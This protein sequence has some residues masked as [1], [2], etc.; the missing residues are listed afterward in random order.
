MSSSPVERF[1]S[2]SSEADEFSS[3]SEAADSDRV[4]QRLPDFV[5]FPVCFPVR[6][7]NR[8]P[9]SS[10]T[11]PELAQRT[12][13]SAKEVRALQ[14]R[15]FKIAPRGY[16][17]REQFR[18]TLG[19][20][21]MT[22][23]DYLPNRMFAVFDADK[24]GVLTFAEY[25]KSFAVLLRGSEEERMK[26][27]FQLSDSS[28]T[29][30]LT[31]SDFKALLNACW[32]TT[33][34][35]LDSGGDLDASEIQEMFY[36]I[37]A[38]SPVISLDQYSE[39][40]RSNVRLLSILGLTARPT[41]SLETSVLSEVGGGGEL[42]SQ[43]RADLCEL[44]ADLVK[45]NGDN[46]VIEKLTEI[47]NKK[48]QPPSPSSAANVLLVGVNNKTTE[49][50]KKG[51]GRKML[52]GPRKG[53]AVH[54]GHENWNMVLSMMI[55]IRLAVGRASFEINRPLTN[56]DFDVK[57]KFS[58]VPQM[59]NFLDSK[60]SSKV[61]VTRFIDYAPL[62]FRKLREELAGITEDDYTRSVGPE[63][64]LGNMVL[65]NLSSLAELS[66]EG[67]GG[68][69]FYYTAD[70]RFMI[71]TVSPTEKRLLK[72]MLK[73]YY[74]HLKENK[75]SLIVRFYGLH[76]LRVKSDP[77]LFKQGKYRND[78]KIFF[79]VM[80]NLFNT[81][82]E[83]HKRFDLKGSWVGRSVGGVVDPTL[84]L[85]DNDFVELG[86]KISV[87]PDAKQKLHI[88]IKNDLLFFSKHNIV[89]YSLLLGIHIAPPGT[90]VTPD[91][92]A[93]GFP[94]VDG[95]RVYYLGIIDILCQYDT[96]KKL[97]TFFKSIRFDRK[98]ISAVPA[99]EYADRFLDF[100]S[101][102]IV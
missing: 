33:T 57:D 3:F 58:I 95:T 19:M 75:E 78:Q 74:M 80:G 25:L 13:L 92:Y 59:S 47:L 73:E 53:L 82:L 24:D 86:E 11:I 30:G 35:L 36:E 43:L 1:E 70:G 93:K 61:K 76:G 56:V 87:G 49:A 29:G 81:S 89:D 31:F 41:Q 98:G 90:V 8:E 38:G 2:V 99:L 17:T 16:M 48:S 63:Q 46:S 18:S 55:G 40:V 94:S 32:T 51:G 91:S 97:E 14:E 52:F 5:S 12:G 65:G 9:S 37:S 22:P 67:K 44:R 100:I 39:A 45:K 96:K 62:V 15:F 6:P 21:G 27:S 7:K 84:A 54:F 102:H 71:K 66:T 77:I 34:A 10:S 69:F 23:N 85:K 42:L 60:V 72:Q 26:L 88:L 64:L 83:V 68:A 20:L 50:S 101:S 4:A 28:G 79:V